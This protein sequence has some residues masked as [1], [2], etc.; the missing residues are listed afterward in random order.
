MEAHP[1]RTVQKLVGLGHVDSP[2]YQLDGYYDKFRPVPGY[3]DLPAGAKIGT[4]PCFIMVGWSGQRS[5][6][7]PMRAGRRLGCDWRILLPM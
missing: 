6:C 3:I 1:T 5:P 4:R 7:R 2:Y